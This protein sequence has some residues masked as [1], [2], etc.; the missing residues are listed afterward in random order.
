MLAESPVA[1]GLQPLVASLRG[2]MLVAY[3]ELY[4]P[5]N[6]SPAGG[7]VT[8]E[9]QNGDRTLPARV[10]A[11]MEHAGAGRWTATARYPLADAQPGAHLAVVTL[12]LAGSDPIRLSRPFAVERKK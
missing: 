8:L 7:T 6:W 12:T 10:P 3:L 1:E 11:V 9:I 4:A 2:N 5:E